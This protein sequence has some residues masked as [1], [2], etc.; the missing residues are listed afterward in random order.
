M[1]RTRKFYVNLLAKINT[2]VNRKRFMVRE[3][4]SL[5]YQRILYIYNCYLVKVDLQ[6][7][8]VFLIKGIIILVNL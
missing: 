8:I 5:K 6:K 1:Y 4:V 2:S 7:L 3:P